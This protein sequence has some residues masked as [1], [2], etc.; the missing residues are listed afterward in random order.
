MKLNDNGKPLYI[1]DNDDAFQSYNR[2]DD[3]IIINLTIDTMHQLNETYE[4]K[5]EKKWDRNTEFKTTN[6]TDFDAKRGRFV[7]MK[8]YIQFNS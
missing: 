3:N 8:I 4:K 1:E 6:Q 2:W 5:A 7:V